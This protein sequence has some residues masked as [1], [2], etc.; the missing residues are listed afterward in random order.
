MKFELRDIVTIEYEK[1][2]EITMEL[3]LK[4]TLAALLVSFIIMSF[5]FLAY[6]VNPL[7]AFFSIFSWAYFTPG[8]FAATIARTIPLLLCGVGLVIAFKALFWNIGAEGQLLMGAVAA[9]WV[10]LF[11]PGVPDF[12]ML[13]TI[14]IMAFLFGAIWGVIP[15]ILKVK[16][17]AN[18]VIT[19]LMMNY[20]AI[21][22]VKY[23]VYGPWKGKYVFN[24]PYSDTFPESAWEPI[25]PGTTVHLITLAIAII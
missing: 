7:F 19:T 9:T 23:L 8:G 5:I 15:A 25:I 12:L 4:I 10:A 17:E 24:F 2:Q 16:F 18:E 13:P 22:L 6:G 11:L 20:I 1:R 14:Y 21:K 3:T